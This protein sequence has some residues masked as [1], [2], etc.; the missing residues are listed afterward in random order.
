MVLSARGLFFAACATLGGSIYGA[1]AAQAV[2]CDVNDEVQQCCSAQHCGGKV[3]NH[4]D[5]HN[6]RRS[7]GKSWHLAS[8]GVNPAVCVSPPH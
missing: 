4:K 3:L 2:P 7:G 8:D 1:S 5:E 6:C